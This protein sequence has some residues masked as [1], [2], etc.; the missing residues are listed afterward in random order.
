[1]SALKNSSEAT[2][3]VRV[4]QKPTDK[5]IEKTPAKIQDFVEKP[6]SHN[7]FNNNYLLH[8][9]TPSLLTAVLFTCTELN[10]QQDT[11]QEVAQH[12]P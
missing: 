5:R 10:S 4:Q 6:F 1:M 12:I 8:P 9:P 2:M 7:S 3:F 11:C